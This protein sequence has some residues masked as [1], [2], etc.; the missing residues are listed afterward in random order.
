MSGRAMGWLPLI[1]VAKKDICICTQHI[2]TARKT[3]ALSLIIKKYGN[4]YLHCT[5]IKI[6]KKSLPEV[7]S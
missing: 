6:M 3:I 1:F 7:L 2:Q 4:M 5:R